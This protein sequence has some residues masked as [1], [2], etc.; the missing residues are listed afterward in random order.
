MTPPILDIDS[1][2]D[3]QPRGLPVSCFCLA[4]EAP[5]QGLAT[6]LM[7]HAAASVP[8]CRPNAARSGLPRELPCPV[9]SV[10]RSFRRRRASQAVA[11][12]DLRRRLLF[13][14]VALLIV[15]AAASSR[16]SHLPA[17]LA[18]TLSIMPGERRRSSMRP[19]A[20]RPAHRPP[21]WLRRR[22]RGRHTCLFPLGQAGATPSTSRRP[23]LG[24]A[25]V[26]LRHQPQ[27]PLIG[28]DFALIS[29]PARTP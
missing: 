20:R 4:V 9:A 3:H 23:A 24:A 28:S 26:R 7:Q 11:V 17:P 29:P 10:A 8:C 21:G 6:H 27:P 19:T 14:A 18:L 25:S 5:R 1:G 15:V 16:R 22:L 13:C 2:R 12:W